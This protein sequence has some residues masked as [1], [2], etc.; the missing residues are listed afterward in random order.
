MWERACSRRWCVSQPMHWL[1]HGLREQA[2]SHIIDLHSCNRMI[3]GC[4][5][6]HYARRGPT[7]SLPPIHGPAD[8]PGH[9]PP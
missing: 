2:R 6:A 3:S 9:S 4:R 8:Q 1:I 5:P 7:P